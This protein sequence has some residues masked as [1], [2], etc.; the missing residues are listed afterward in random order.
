MMK[1]LALGPVIATVLMVIVA[2]PV[3]CTFRLSFGLLFPTLAEPKLNDVGVNVSR[4]DRP[5][6]LRETV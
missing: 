4:P 5:V 1:L 3:F 6:T 2:L